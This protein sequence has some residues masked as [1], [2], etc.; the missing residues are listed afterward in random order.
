MAP[1]PALAAARFQAMDRAPFTAGEAQAPSSIDGIGF[2][3]PTPPEPVDL[4]DADGQL[5]WPLEHVASEVDPT[6]Q[7][8]TTAGAEILAPGSGRVAFATTDSVTVDHGNGLL[9]RIGALGGVEAQVGDLV[10][11]GQALG[12]VGATGQFQITG[13][14][15]GNALEFQAL[16][17]MFVGEEITQAP[18][19]AAVV[20]TAEAG[21]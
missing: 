21:S 8:W 3:P 15:D 5:H 16:R 2:D 11:R 6:G 10:L 19:R 18:R 20:P 12:K 9:T 1:S 4:R 17:Q 14:K 13:I 7:V